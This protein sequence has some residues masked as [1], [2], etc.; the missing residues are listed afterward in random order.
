MKQHFAMMAAYNTWANARL[1]RM[2]RE[3]TREQYLRDV[4]AYFK[5]LCGT[6]NHVLVAD[7]IW[8]W[9]LTG[10]G[11]APA[12]LDAVLFDDLGELSDARRMEDERIARFVDELTD[13]E[14]E[15][16]VEY[17]TGKGPSRQR[18]R[19][20]LA[21]V[22]NHQTHHRGQAH[23]ILTALGVKEPE[24]LDLIRMIREGASR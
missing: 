7:R 22:F 24:S 3:L 13:A 16:V 10:E 9:R 11:A 20:V 17:R 21:H 1:Y 6:L 2:A 8:M 4:G 14:F 5:S 23:G 12:Q 15:A 18:L 19:E